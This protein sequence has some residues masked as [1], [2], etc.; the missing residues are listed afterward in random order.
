M[1]PICVGCQRFFRPKKTGMYFIEGMP[2][3]NDVPPG[4][5]EPHRWQP[6]KLW[7]GDLFECEGC[8]ATIISGVGLRP[9]RER[10]HSDFTAFVNSFG[11]KFQV[12]DC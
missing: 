11:A 4:T 9:I 3:G 2:N 8:G 1:R 10:H 6:Y 12:N 7:A 5:A